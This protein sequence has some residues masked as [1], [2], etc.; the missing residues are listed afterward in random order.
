MKIAVVPQY[1]ELMRNE[2]FNDNEYNLMQTRGV[3]RAGF[4]AL[5]NELERRGNTV[6][7]IDLMDNKRIDVC[8]FHDINYQYLKEMMELNSDVKLIY[9]MFEAPSFIPFNSERS[10]LTFY[11]VF[12][13][14]L[15]WNN[16]LSG[17]KKRI[18][19]Y[20]LPYRHDDLQYE[21]NK[22][23]NQKKLLTNIS[24]RRY[25]SHPN[26]LY[27]SREQLINF[28]ENNHPEDFTLYGYNWNDAHSPKDIYWRG[29]NPTIYD[30]YEG[31]V[32]DK[33]DAYHNHKFAICFENQSNISGWITEKIFDCFRFGTVP[34]YWGADDIEK[35]IPEDTF[36]DY[37]D[38]LSPVD[39][40]DYISNISE[41]EYNEY[42]TA[43][44]K[45]LKTS[46][47]FKPET[48]ARVVSDSITSVNLNKSDN[49]K[50]LM[51]DIETMARID[52]IRYDP[53]SV[54]RRELVREMVK[55]LQSSPRLLIK[56]PE[57][58][59]NGLKE[60]F[61]T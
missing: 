31:L 48:F 24:S 27:S 12:D 57:I 49:Y 60:I 58:T 16:D 42:L 7:T 1:K 22:P 4:A 15:T 52:K 46:N 43:A 21:A 11:P 41:D 39:L 2:I 8:L 6:K 23:F 13:K 32:D 44:Q 5:K 28:Y 53:A 19:T 50:H 3:D 54:C 37:R 14:I 17:K 45:Y 51:D 20:K 9:I 18:D 61:S 47:E 25:S 30:C 59:I 26:E 38:F 36:V 56:N 55:V 29:L 35:H 10:L 40:H 34:V 33:T